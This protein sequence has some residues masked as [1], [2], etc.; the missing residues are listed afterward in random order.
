MTDNT[1]P[2]PPELPQQPAASIDRYE[3]VP[4]PGRGDILAVMESLLKHPGRIIWEISN[5]RA[6]SVIVALALITVGSLAI[7]GVVVGSLTGGSQLWIAPAKITIGSLLSLLIC[8]PSL[9]IFLCLSGSDGSLRQVAG[10]LISSACLTA[11]LLISF[12]PV[13]WVFSQST[14]SIGLMGFLNLIFW[15]VAMWFGMGL[16]KRCMTWANHSAKGN[17]RAWMAIYLIVSLQMT[18]SL[19]PIIGHA[20]TFLPSEKQFFLAHW[21]E[22]LS[23]NS[24]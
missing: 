12:A 14:D 23:T 3:Y 4:M 5:G 21:Q 9:Y 2:L 10:M 22:C 6:L 1:Q 15:L 11:L 17:L 19:R 7:Y 18:T 20:D 24:K 16:L 8:L 13:A